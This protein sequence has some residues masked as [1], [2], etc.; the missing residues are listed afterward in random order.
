ME[1]NEVIGLMSGSSLDGIDIIDAVF[2]NDGEWRY[3][4]I[5][6]ET[7]DYSDI[8]GLLFYGRTV[9]TA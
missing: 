6:K 1:K 3:E 2:W 4:I 9:E 5:A 7:I 8:R